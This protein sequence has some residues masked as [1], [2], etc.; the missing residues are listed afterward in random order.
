M[1][2]ILFDIASVTCTVKPVKVNITSSAQN[3]SKW[4]EDLVTGNCRYSYWSG[5]HLS[6]S[7][8]FFL[9]MSLNIRLFLPWF[10]FA[11]SDKSYFSFKVTH[12]AQLHICFSEP[13]KKTAT[14]IYTGLK[15]QRGWIEGYTILSPYWCHC[16]FLRF[17]FLS[18]GCSAVSSQC[19][20]W[21]TYA[22]SVLLVW[23]VLSVLYQSPS[24]V[25]SVEVACLSGLRCHKDVR[26]W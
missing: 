12:T 24:S 8:S 5:S 22:S 23:G 25:R 10:V 14:H 6:K 9:C 17:P 18:D 19:Q 26:K 21:F 4:I 7:V 3:I 1:K 15:V 16:S 20:E 11:I 13:K 2:W